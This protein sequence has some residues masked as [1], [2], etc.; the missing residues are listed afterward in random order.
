M[1]LLASE[2]GARLARW[3]LATHPHEACGVMIGEIEGDDARV[4]RVVRGENLRSADTLDRFE[5]DPAALVAADRAARASGRIIVGVWHTHP[6]RPAL[7]SEADRRGAW[8]EWRALIVPV[9]VAGAGPPRAWRLLR[10]RFV[11]EGVSFYG[12]RTRRNFVNGNG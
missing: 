11:E 7:P 9:T 10:D 6:D 12:S 3:A 8:R 4:R 1:L 5:L 2:E